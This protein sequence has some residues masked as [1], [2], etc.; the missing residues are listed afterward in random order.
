MASFGSGPL[1]G[2]LALDME[3]ATEEG[4][5]VQLFQR[6]LRNNVA[7]PTGD[8]LKNTVAFVASPQVGDD[9]VEEVEQGS[10]DDVTVLQDTS[11]TASENGFMLSRGNETT[12]TWVT[13][14]AQARLTW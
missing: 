1:R 4:I 10:D 11:V 14:G 6:P 5:S 3:T 7:P 12:W 13:P 8:L 9:I 2:T